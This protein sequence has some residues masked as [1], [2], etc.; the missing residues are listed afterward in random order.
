MPL[1]VKFAHTNLVAQDWKRLAEFYERV[2]GC[3]PVP[4]KRKLQGKW[5]D[6]S[7]GISGAQVEGIHLRLPG[8]GD[9]GPSLEIFQYNRQGKQ[10]KPTL[11]RPGFAHI[12]F[13]V[14]DVGAARDTVVAA[15][16]APAGETVSVKIPGVGTIT[17]IYVRDPEGNIIELQRWSS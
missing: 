16:G 14:D 9:D 15:G 11:N 2:F 1:R 4:P 10:L 12:A 17:F 5:L 13:T 7:T 8:H 6:D 3:I